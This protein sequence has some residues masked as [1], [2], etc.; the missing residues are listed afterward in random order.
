MADRGFGVGGFAEQ[1]VGSSSSFANAATP[2]ADGGWVAAGAATVSDGRQ[3]MAVVRGAPGDAPVP[4]WTALAP[5]GQGA[6][7]ND[8][9]ALPDGRVVAA[10]QVTLDTPPGGLAFGAAR[11]SAGGDLDPAFG[12][13][14]TTTIGW[15]GYPYA[16]ATAAALQPDG[17]LLTAGIGCAGGSGG[18]RC[19][20]G[21]AVLLLA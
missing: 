6:V 21:T 8:V 4:S 1:Y 13:G 5:V 12:T 7:A 18:P 20:G 16:R 11:F 15:E 14:G 3:A 19:T 9:A 2:M 17:R 10:G